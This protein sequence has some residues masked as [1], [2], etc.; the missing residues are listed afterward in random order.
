MRNNKAYQIELPQF[1][2]FAQTGAVDI[3]QG[4]SLYITFRSCKFP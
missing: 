3:S 4:G 2:L 1:V